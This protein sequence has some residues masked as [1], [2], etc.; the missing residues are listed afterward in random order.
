MWP[1][2]KR[3]LS[4]RELTGEIN[5]LSKKLE[6][7][8]AAQLYPINDPETAELAGFL[9]SLSDRSDI[10][11]FQTMQSNF[12]RAVERYKHDEPKLLQILNDWRESLLILKIVLDENEVQSPQMRLKTSEIERRLKLELGADYIDPSEAVKNSKEKA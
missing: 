12:I 5:I 10:V 11:V 8:I 7:E 9:N 4:Q 3:Q 6:D 2:Q 1:F